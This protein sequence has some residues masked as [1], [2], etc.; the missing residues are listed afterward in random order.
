MISKFF[1]VGSFNQD[2]RIIILHTGIAASD[3]CKRRKNSILTMVNNYPSELLYSSS[4]FR[5]SQVDW[6]PVIWGIGL[7]IT[8]GVLILRWDKGYLAFK[9]MGEQ[10]QQFLEFTD[11]GSKFVFGEEGFEMHPVAF[12]VKDT[13]AQ[14]CPKTLQQKLF[15]PRS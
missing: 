15:F 6:R 8:L 14:Y 12:K 10:V 13:N 9:F 2:Q 3:I 5:L 1:W 7:Q 4:T 11:E